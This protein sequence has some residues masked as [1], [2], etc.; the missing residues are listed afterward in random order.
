MATKLG[1]STTQLTALQYVADGSGTTVEGLTRVF[2][3]LGKSMQKADDDNKK[4]E[5]AFKALGVSMQ[6]VGALSE[7]ELAAKLVR[8]YDLL[9]RSTKATVAITQL[10]GPSFR[11]QIPAILDL[12]KGLDTYTKKALD[13]GAVASPALVKAGQEQETALQ[14]LGLAWKGFANEVAESAGTLVKSVVES[15]SGVLNAVRKALAE[16]RQARE[17]AKETESIPQAE[18]TALLKQ[19][20]SEVYNGSNPNATEGDVNKRFKEL[21]AQRNSAS[22]E[23]DAEMQREMNRARSAEQARVQAAA[24]TAGGVP[25][26]NANARDAFKDALTDMQRSLTLTQT[27]TEYERTLFEVQRGRY[28]EFSKSQKD[29]L[30]SLANQIDKRNQLNSVAE[31]QLD[32]IREYDQAEQQANETLKQRIDYENQASKANADRLRQGAQNIRTGISLMRP[33]QSSIERE[34]D[35]DLA[36]TALEAQRAIGELT[37]YIEGYEARVRQIREAEA[38]ATAAIREAARARQDYAADWTNGAK[39]AF[40]SYLEDAGNVAKKT[41]DLFSSAFG[42]AEDALFEFVTTGK[43]NFKSLIASILSDIARYL[44]QTTIMA[45]IIASLRSLMGFADGGVFSGGSPMAFANG[46][47]FMSGRVTPFANGTVV[48]SPTLFPMSGGGM[49][50]MGEAGPEAI[51]PLNR[52]PSG[53]LGV[54]ATGISNVSNTYAINISVGSVDSPERVE[55]LSKS[56]KDAVIAITKQTVANEARRG[57]SLNPTRR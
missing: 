10:L 16:M 51:M 20:R 4:T 30:L 44:I 31:R 2:D 46:A 35:S 40:A 53:R 45:P 13:F 28:A 26:G 14:D 5:W 43:L 6:E 9:G 24:A 3:K 50:L 34:R 39:D 57:G 33:G 56:L 11:E 49:G 38:D 15:L 37:P 19:A 54:K 55:E 29:E 23:A 32:L 12:G 47:A 52:D 41:Q 18:R 27:A 42:K 22:R 21:M 36:A 17:Q 1:I 7:Q 25:S 8:N 48:S